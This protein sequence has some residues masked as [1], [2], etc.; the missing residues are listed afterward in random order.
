[1]ALAAARAGNV[2]DIVSLEAMVVP[3]VGDE[4]GLCRPV[5]GRMLSGIVVTVTRG[6]SPSLG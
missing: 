1:V 5:P 3:T 4:L 2:L 6:L